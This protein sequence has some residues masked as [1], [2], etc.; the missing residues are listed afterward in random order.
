MI[1]KI[2]ILDINMWSNSDGDQLKDIFSNINKMNYLKMHQKLLT[3]S[4]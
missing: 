1:L 4:Y 3:Y 2:M